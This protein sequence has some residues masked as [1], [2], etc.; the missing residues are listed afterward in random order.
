MSD[1]ALHF[2]IFSEL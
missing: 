1:F 2:C